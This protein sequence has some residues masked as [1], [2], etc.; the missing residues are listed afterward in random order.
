M[1]DNCLGGALMHKLRWISLVAWL[2]IC[3]SSAQSQSKNT[4]VVIGYSG[5]G[6]AHD[7]L[8]IMASKRIFEKHGVN[9]T[10][11]YIGSGSLMNQAVVGGSVQFTT[12]DLPS[13]IQSALAGVDFKVLSVTIN[14]LD[15][16]LMTL[17]GIRTP[18]E[19]K[20][21]KL[22]ISRFGSVS[23]IVTRMVLRYWGLEP[24]KDVPLIQVG[25]TPSRIAAIFSGQVD[26]GLINP[27]DVD[28]IVASGCCFLLADLSA[29]DIP[30]ARFGVAGLGSYVKANPETAQ[31]VIAGFVEGIHYYKTNPA[32]GVE[33][34]QSRG[35][36][37]RAA[38]EI[39]Q[40]IADSYR[41]TPDPELISI[42]GVLESLPEERARKVLPE[43]FVDSGPWERVAKSGLVEKLYGKKGPVTK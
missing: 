17:K 31:K 7:L 30:Y 29:L 23:D 16:A 41:S 2:L 39:Y 37:P 3:S 21:K 38:K 28:R 10:S 43:N 18:K 5:V 42:K 15:G 36:D 24:I 35:V 33:A 13:Q 34:L 27:T 32:V 26:G 9:A 4:D 6:I 20:G 19:L 40:K 11:I 22:A 8:K 1:A 14:R 12:S 25:N